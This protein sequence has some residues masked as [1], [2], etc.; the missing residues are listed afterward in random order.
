MEV[1]DSQPPQWQ[2]TEGQH[3][4]FQVCQHDLQASCDTYEGRPTL[5]AGQ[6]LLVDL[7]RM[8]SLLLRQMALPGDLEPGFGNL[9]VI[10]Q[11]LTSMLTNPHNLCYGNAPFRCRCWAGAFAEDLS[12]A[13][14]DSHPAA[15]QFLASNEP[16][17]LTGLE[18]MDHVWKHFEPGCQDDVGHFLGRLWSFSGSN[19]FGGRFCHIHENGRL[20]DRE[21]VPLNL[22]FPLDLT[23]P[24]LEDLVTY[25]SNEGKG[26]YLY[27]TPGALVLHLQRFQQAGDSRTKHEQPVEIPVRVRIPFSEDGIHVHKASYKVISLILHK[28]QGHEA[29]HYVAIH[30]LDNAY[31]YADD[32]QYLTPLPEEH[33]RQIVQVW[34]VLEAADELDPDTL[35]AWQPVLKKSRGHYETLNLFSGNVTQFGHKV[36]DWIWT[37]PNHL[38]F[39]QETHM[40]TKTMETALQYF[41]TRGW[42]AYGVAAHPTG[43]GGTSG[44]FITLHGQKHLTHHIQ[45]Y[46]QE[47][48]GWTAIGLQRADK[49][50]LLIQVY[51]RT[52]ETL[53]SPRNADIL[54]QLLNLLDHAHAPFIIGGDW[55]NSPDAL[56]ATVIMSK[57]QCQVTG[58]PAGFQRSGQLH[59]SPA[60]LGGA[61]ETSLRLGGH[62]FLRHS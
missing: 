19:F 33:Q 57:F 32:D 34:L 11:G 38:V 51:L 54:A 7:R 9:Y 24:T 37:K 55:Q 15:R 2:L 41:N 10:S 17:T 58:L 5:Q 40:G 30:C 61:V 44:G 12:V 52:G 29:G 14:G 4:L 47:G 23:R 3:G 36:Q 42:R 22:L 31:W 25:W 60:G 53:Q 13:W 16:Q 26:Q 50:I 27:G 48:N 62:S 46:T 21:Q 28:G 59:S 20:E 43:N 6:Q 1:E 39:L 45:T 49:L 35:E 56:A 18:G 8:Q